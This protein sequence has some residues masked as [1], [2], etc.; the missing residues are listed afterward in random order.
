MKLL[1]MINP[2][3]PL[4]F[5]LNFYEPISNFTILI[6]SHRFHKIV[7]DHRSKKKK[8]QLYLLNPKQQNS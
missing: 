8:Q 4:V 3:L 1:I 5:H 2:Q 7:V 6:H